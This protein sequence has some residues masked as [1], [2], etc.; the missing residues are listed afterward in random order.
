MNEVSIERP[1]RLLVLQFARLGDT[2]QS[3][4]A[5]RAAHQL[6]P[7]LKITLITHENFADAAKK[8]PWVNDVFVFPTE[9]ILAP[10]LSGEKTS[11]ASLSEIA[12]WVAPL[13][14]EP[15]DFIVNW[16][17]TEASSFLTGLIPGKVKLGYSRR[18]DGTF[19]CLDGW[20]HYIQSVVQTETE[21]GIHLTDILTTQLLTSLQ[22]HVGE[23]KDP[24]D[25]TVTSKSFFKFK[26]EAF[27]C[28]GWNHPGK[29]WIAI[30]LGASHASKQWDPANWAK[31]ASQI[32]RRHDDMNIILL[33]GPRERALEKAFFDALYADIGDRFEIEDRIASK[34]STTPFDLWAQILSGSQWLFSA[35]TAA[36]HMASVLGT[37]IL[38]VSVGPVRFQETGPYG[39]GHYVLRGAEPDTAYAAWTYALT[40]WQH[41]RELP[42]ENH[43]E[44]LGL[45][46]RTASIEV[47]RSKIRPSDQGG[48][49]HFEPMMNRTLD[50]SAWYSQVLSH[51]AREWYCGWV[52][53]IGQEIFR[54]EIT[55]DLVKSLRKL[56]EGVDVVDQIF[57][58]AARTATRLHQ[59]TKKL[60]SEHL[61]KM[62]D[63][64]EIQELGAKLQELEALIVRVGATQEPLAVFSRLTKVLMHNI[65]GKKISELAEETAGVH[66]FLRVGSQAMRQWIEHTLSLAKPIAL[67]PQAQVIP[68]KK[69]KKAPEPTV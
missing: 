60:K 18:K 10:I 63:R 23:P 5:L 12:T 69:E 25:A 52:P 59:K 45:K 62:Q 64:A 57:G 20:S 28:E 29:K 39:N 24:G 49:V 30:Q 67:N 13:V 27:V 65:Q 22:I 16:S 14:E 55:T 56:K 8:T 51:M 35:D 41:R 32:L 15:W 7:N 1:I 38:N 58:E 21:Q 31:L 11:R 34:V 43:F 19:A 46:D 40:E 61:M 53:P 3:L 50:L 36:I 42:I 44:R 48:G 6:Y 2:I 17:F 47:Y 66:Q 26:R 9:K 33:G 54:G 68:L 37:R 4:M